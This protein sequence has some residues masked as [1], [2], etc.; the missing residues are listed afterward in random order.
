MDPDDG[1]SVPPPQ[2][3]ARSA[4]ARE[5]SLKATRNVAAIANRRVGR[6]LARYGAAS[7]R[8]L[9]SKIA[10]A[11]R[12][13]LR[14]A[15]RELNAE[16]NKM[17]E[18][19][20]IERVYESENNLPDIFALP[21]AAP[22]DIETRVKE[23]L[24]LYGVFNHYAGDEGDIGR[25]GEQMIERAF[26]ASPNYTIICQRWGDVAAY[27]GIVLEQQ[28][29]GLVLA[30]I[31]LQGRSAADAVS[32]IE[33]KNRREWIYPQDHRL[34]KLIR[35]AYRLDVVGFLFARR[36]AGTTFGYT[37]KKVGALGI[38]TFA[39]FAPPE[40]ERELTPVR[41]KG[42]LGFH[43]LTFS[44][45]VPA[46]LQRRV[47]ALAPRILVARQRMRA[48]RQFVKPY[49]DDLAD[50]SV[51][52]ARRNELFDEMSLEIKEFDNPTESEDADN[53]ERAEGPGN[54]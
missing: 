7:K 39:Q 9:E 23:I 44:T 48:V 10:E 2:V 1:L 49:L 54:E 51:R 50:P 26:A 33:V 38:E 36:I 32:L 29:D 53:E 40:L 46:Y 14:V 47:D 4:T 5:A 21:D 6:I 24:R 18:R 3:L 42:G 31:P 34:W 27:N 13:D 37:L 16:I 17:L 8:M 20:Q 28:S 15:P 12:G 41:E 11:G 22:D 52:G 30:S 43:D 35:N 25:A 45:E 19:G